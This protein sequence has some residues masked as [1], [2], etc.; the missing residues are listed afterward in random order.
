MHGMVCARRC[1]FYLLTFCDIL[2]AKT[3]TKTDTDTD[4]G[5][6]IH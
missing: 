2:I 6:T 4:Y 1:A 5:N 3:D